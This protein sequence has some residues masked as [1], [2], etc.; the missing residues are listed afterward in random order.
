MSSNGKLILYLINRDLVLY[1]DSVSPLHAVITI[2]PEEIKNK[3]VRH[4]ISLFHKQL[5][6]ITRKNRKKKYDSI[7]LQ[8]VLRLIPWPKLDHLISNQ[9]RLTVYK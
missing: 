3:K 4:N 1:K 5:F 7:V 9:T 2:D 8:D 6:K